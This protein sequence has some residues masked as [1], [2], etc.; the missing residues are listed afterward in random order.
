MPKPSGASGAAEELLEEVAERGAV[1]EHALELVRRDRP[2]AEV[3]VALE[4]IGPR[5]SGALPL[6][7][8]LP[9]RPELVV[10]LPLFRIAEH[11]IGLVD[12]LESILGGLVA[13]VNVG[14]MLAGK[15]PEG[16]AD[17][18]LGG[19]PR[20]AQDRVVV[21]ESGWHLVRRYRDGAAAKPRTRGILGRSP[22]LRRETSRRR[23]PTSTYSSALH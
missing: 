10:L 13:L 8:L 16:G 20:N 4:R 19:R 11:L 15:L 5:L 18:L 9:A 1:A 7:V 21:L 12:L 6:L 14:V 17:L 3:L 2:V 23:P 22:R